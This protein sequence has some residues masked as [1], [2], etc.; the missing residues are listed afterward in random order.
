M[1]GK[2]GIHWYIQ[3]LNSFTDVNLLKL[4]PVNLKLYNRDDTGDKGLIQKTAR[5]LFRTQ[6]NASISWT[7]S[8]MKE[9]CLKTQHKNKMLKDGNWA[10]G[11]DSD[12]QDVRV[13]WRKLIRYGRDGPI[14]S[15]RT[16]C[17]SKLYWCNMIQKDKNVYKLLET[18][19]WK[20][21]YF[22]LL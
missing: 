15:R 4:I 22:N 19:S 8:N 1:V 10:S 13:C 18:R 11:N 17:K 9:Q 7:L 12:K 20:H 21:H 6:K 14:R 2:R 3:P 5:P 16:V